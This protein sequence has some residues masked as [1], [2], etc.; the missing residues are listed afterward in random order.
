MNRVGAAIKIPI[1]Y[2]VVAAKSIPDVPLR[3]ACNVFLIINLVNIV[4][5]LYKD[6]DNH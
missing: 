5:F 6:Q 3:S 2:A 1:D 4:I